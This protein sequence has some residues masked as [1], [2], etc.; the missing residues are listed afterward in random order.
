M[1]IVGKPKQ[2]APPVLPEL[3]DLGLKIPIPTS[4]FAPA[5]TAPV[6]P[7]RVTLADNSQPIETVTTLSPV[8]ATLRRFVNSKPFVCHS[9][10]KEVGW[11]PAFFLFRIPPS[12]LPL[13]SPAHTRTPAILFLS[14]A[15]FTTL[16]I[17]GG[18]CRPR[19]WPASETSPKH[20]TVALPEF[21]FGNVHGETEA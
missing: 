5:N 11:V 18:G 14:C 21:P 2:A 16:C 8:S 13:A 20:P 3:C 6:S 4:S 10:K 7:F 17:P 1:V 19:F 15:Y 9:Y 12:S